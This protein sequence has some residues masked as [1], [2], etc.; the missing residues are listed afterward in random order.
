MDQTP[1]R[2]LR[3][4][5]I[6]PDL[7][8][9]GA[10]RLIVDTAVGLQQKGHDVEIFTSY[11]DPQHCFEATR[12]GTLKVHLMRTHIPRSLLGCFHSIF[13]IFQQLSLV[14]QLLLSL[15][16]FQY[17]GTLPQGV[18]K[19]LSSAPPMQP[20]DVIFMD[21]QSVGVPWIKL[22]S[23]TR[24]VFYCH[25]PDKELSN[26]IAQQ[27]AIA[28]GDSGPSVFRK[29]YRFPLDLLEEGTI[30][31]AD[32]IMVNSE[33]TQQHFI[34]SFYRLRRAPRVVYPGIDLSAYDEATIK[35]SAKK[36]LGGESAPTSVQRGIHDIVAGTDRPTII[37]VNRFEAKKNVALALEAFAGLR[38]EQASSGDG[39]A[40]RFRLVIAGGYDSRVRDNIATLDELQKQA[41]AL[42]LRHITLFYTPPSGEPPASLPREGELENASVFFLP[43]LPGPLLNTLLANA[44]VRTL[45]YTPTDEHFGIVP[46]E[47]MACGIP[48]LATN[49]GGPVESVV[50]AG[51][52]AS[53]GTFTNESGTG[54]LRHPSP[55]VW[56]VALLSLASVSAAERVKFATAARQRVKERFSLEVMTAHIESVLYEAESQGVVKNEEGL[57]QWSSTV[58]VFC[59]MMWAYLWLISSM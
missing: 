44:S 39:A 26:T 31:Y 52:D 46:L 18:F 29:L 14:Y 16:I 49:T 24:V 28:R 19:R 21:Q 6:H 40:S 33:F 37:S 1:E 27:R 3:I 42:G 38:K 15:L 48:V 53:T 36:L 54:L 20:F 11:H 57:L 17:P 50:D 32:K 43:S 8:I 9:G 4:A 10:E 56:T 51:W 13:S 34:K 23:F 2:R 22:L 12:D 41:T 30:D 47:A 59:L 7:G 35:V 45:L 58:G 5:V 25:F 55:S